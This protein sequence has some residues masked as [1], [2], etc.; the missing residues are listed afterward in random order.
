MTHIRPNTHT[1]RDNYLVALMNSKSR[2]GSA[3]AP[4]DAVLHCDGATFILRVRL[5]ERRAGRE[6]DEEE[7]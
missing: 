1:H 2:G 4:A 3:H 5:K 7:D 6:K